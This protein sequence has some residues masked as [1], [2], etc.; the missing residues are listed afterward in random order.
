MAKYLIK[1]GISIFLLNFLHFSFAAEPDDQL[2]GNTLKKIFDKPTA[3]LAVDAIAVASNF[4]LASWSQER[5][6]GRAL[7]R[8]KGNQWEIVVCGGKDLKKI[9]ALAKAGVP[10]TDA[11]LLVSDLSK[12]ELQLP[13][14]LRLQFDSFSLDNQKNHNSHH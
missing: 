12:K 7:L 3:P 2:V 13:A 4:S 10:S 9:S 11:E 14:S 8:K 5:K 1:L 6:A